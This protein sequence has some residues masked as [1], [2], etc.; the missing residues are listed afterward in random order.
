MRETERPDQTRP[1]CLPAEPQRGTA[2]GHLTPLAFRWDQ[3][4]EP[5]SHCRIHQG[6]PTDS[7]FKTV[8]AETNASVYRASSNAA[9]TAEAAAASSSQH[10]QQQLSSSS[11]STSPTHGGCS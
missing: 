5:P 8:E 9:R 10:D 3:R 1:Y 7:S 6:I 4:E 11:S 2:T